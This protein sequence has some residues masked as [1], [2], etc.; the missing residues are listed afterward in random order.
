MKAYKSKLGFTLIELLVVIAIIAVLAAIL[1]P[2]FAKARE[3]AKTATC[4]SNLKQ[5]GLA[6]IQ[7][8][9]DHDGFG[10]MLTWNAG[11]TDYP[12]SNGL[13][14][15]GPYGLPIRNRWTNDINPV[16]VC[17]G[18]GKKTTYGLPWAGGGSWPGQTPQ[19]NIDATN[20]YEHMGLSAANAMMVADISIP[21]ELMVSPDSCDFYGHATY[22][23][24]PKGAEKGT[25]AQPYQAKYAAHGNRNNMCFRDGHVK[26]LTQGEMMSGLNWWAA[27]EAQP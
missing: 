5:I 7:Y 25:P 16:F 3:K 12:G 6:L 24:E 21:P 10:P 23:Y 15:L 26:G 20:V 8:C 2:V 1:F 11:D 27:I 9:G 19:W 17:D 4:V 14:K 18:K 22:F 13:H